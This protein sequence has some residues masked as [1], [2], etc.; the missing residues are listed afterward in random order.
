[1][2]F[3]Y[4]RQ[5]RQAYRSQKVASEY[6]TTIDGRLT[7]SLMPARIVAA[8]ERSIVGTML[9]RAPHDTVVD[10]PVGTGKLAPIFRRFGSQ[11]LALDLSEAMLE[12]ARASFGAVSHENVDFAVCDAEELAHRYPGPYDICVCLRL[13]HRV[14]SDVKRRILA[15]LSSIAPFSIVSFGIRSWY[16]PVRSALRTAV[17]RT[18]PLHYCEE[19]IRDIRIMVASSFEVLDAKRVLPGFS[20]EMIFFLRSKRFGIR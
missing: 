11:V 13:L 15:A 4:E 8:R 7:W 14:P 3:D 5:T 10:I 9:S 18:P 20:R 16:E 6:H 1:M 19:P 2:A 17:F 12:V